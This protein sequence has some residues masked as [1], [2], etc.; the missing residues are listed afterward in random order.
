MMRLL[1][2]I[3]FLETLEIKS[4]SEQFNS[5]PSTPPAP[6]S[7]PF[8][9]M[10]RLLLEGSWQE[11]IV[12]FSWL[13]IPPTAHLT[14]GSNN[15]AYPDFDPSNSALF[16]S[17]AEVFRAH[18][19]SALSR[20]AHYDEPA[21]AA[22]FEMFTVSASPASATAETADHTVGTEHCDLLPAHLQLSV[23]WTDDPDVRQRL[24]NIF[25]TLPIFTMARTLHLDPFL[26]QYYPSMI[27]VY[28]NV[29][30]LKLES[31]VE[32][33]LDDHGI[34]EQGALF[35]ALTCVCFIGVDL[36]AE[37]LPRLVD[38]LLVTHSALQDVGFSGCRLGGKVLVKRSVEEAAQRFQERGI[39]TSVTNM[40]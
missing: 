18:F 40:G 13:A 38:Q 1:Q 10:R 16:E 35:P 19:A 24:L 27:A 5:L 32:A 30:S 11:N 2:N 34:A 23:P 28:T 37:V 31:S 12:I 3:P 36:S 7:I 25:S 9:N 20:G 8:P 4:A 26:W 21:I 22:D 17:A 15:D 29:R 39:T 6:R 33:S 14:I